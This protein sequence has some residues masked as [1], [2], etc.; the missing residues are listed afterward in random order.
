MAKPYLLKIATAILALCTSGV[1]ACSIRVVYS[2]IA[3]PPYQ[4]GDGETVPDRPGVGVE[5][6]NEAASRIGC[7]IDWRRVP[8]R[9]VHLELERGAADATLGF[10]YSDERSAYAVY[11]MKQGAPDANFSVAT[12]SYYVYVRA[13]STLNW[14][15]KRFNLQ[16]LT[17]GVNPG[18]SAGQDLRKLGVM[19]EE[20]PSTE[21]NLLKLQS[22]RI[23][24]YVM[25]DFPTDTFMREHGIKSLVKLQTPFSSKEY[26]VPFSKQFFA[27]SPELVSKFWAQM[28][29]VRKA[30]GRELLRKYG[31]LN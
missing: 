2:D 22:G 3:T 15:G 26:Y 9:R 17:V 11:P 16:G 31:D 5:L 8:N 20:A 1:F 14:D 23:A 21:N 27:T 4:L 13:D 7:K 6:V 24:A 28:A 29:E 18:Y 19:V 25:Q 30:Q 10:S 12:L